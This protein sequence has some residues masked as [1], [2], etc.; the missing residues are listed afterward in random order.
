MITLSPHHRCRRLFA[1]LLTSA[2]LLTTAAAQSDKRIVAPGT[3]AAEPAA[4]ARMNARLKEV[5]KDYK[6][7][8][9]VGEFARH[10]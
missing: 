5:A 2:V 1:V 3:W 7:Y 9:D 4:P 8:K 6:Q 10:I